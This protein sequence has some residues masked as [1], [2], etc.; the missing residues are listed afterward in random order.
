MPSDA[1]GIAAALRANR[2]DRSLFQRSV[3]DVLRHIADFLVVRDAG[4][5]VIGCAA[6]H[7]HSH[8]V[9]EILSVAVLPERQGRG[10][11]ALLVRACEERARALGR[12]EL[13]LGT[14]KPAYFA[15]LGYSSGSRWR[16]LLLCGGPG[17][18]ANKLAAVTA[19][20][21]AR[22]LPALV[23]RHTWMARKLAP[24]AADVR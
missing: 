11:G 5:R 18:L 24:N 12:I 22:W 17:I 7:C 3:R 19:Q 14:A 15:R 4:A 16:F 9:A 1:E 8:R 13:W 6:L 2:G 23:G 21:P 10:L 20:P